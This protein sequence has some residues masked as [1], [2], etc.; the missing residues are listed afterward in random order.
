MNVLA[1][2]VTFVYGYTQLLGWFVYKDL[3][4]D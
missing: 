2:D 1:L 3:Y 4:F